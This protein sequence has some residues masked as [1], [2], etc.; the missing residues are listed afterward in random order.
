[1]KCCQSSV[2]DTSL[3]ISTKDAH[4]QMGNAAEIVGKVQNDLSVRAYQA[5]D[6]GSNI[7]KLLVICSVSQLDW[8]IDFDAVDAVVD[9]THRYKEIFY[10]GGD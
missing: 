3:I 7:G 10:E 2:I 1:M 5:T 6:F 9:A 4:L 8:A